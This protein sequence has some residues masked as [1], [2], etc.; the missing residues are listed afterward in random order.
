MEKTSTV[1]PKSCWLRVR[2]RSTAHQVEM[3]K[4]LNEGKVEDE[5]EIIPLTRNSDQSNTRIYRVGDFR[6]F[7]LKGKYQLGPPLFGNQKT[8]A[9][10]L[11]LEIK[12]CSCPGDV[13]YRAFF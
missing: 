11:T 13:L 10:K 1:H 7:F 5:P 3:E 4:K 9:V 6:R 12:G 2:H 8:I